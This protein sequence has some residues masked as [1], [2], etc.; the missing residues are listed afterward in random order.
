M[1]RIY[2]SLIQGDFRG[3]HKNFEAVVLEGDTVWHWWRDNSVSNQPWKRSHFITRG[4]AFPAS[5]IQ[6]NLR[7]ENHSN[8][9][10]VVPLFVGGNVEL[11]HFWHDNSDVNL[12]WARRQR[13]TEVGRRVIGPASLIQS[14]FG[15]PH[16]NFEVIVPVI[17]SSGQP[18]LRHY[19]H[20]N[21]DVQRPWS[22][23][24]QVN[25]PAHHVLGSGCLVQS[26]FGDGSHGNFEVV[27][28]VRMPDGRSVLQHY[29]H[30]NSDVN[31]PW[32]SGQVIW[33]NVK[34][35]GVIIQSSH[36]SPHS[37]FEVVVPIGAPDGRT[38]LQHVWH[39]N[40]DVNL[41]WSRGQIVSEIVSSG[42]N[43]C[44]MESD[45]RRQGRRN[46]ELLV[47][48]GSQSLV[49]Y[50]HPNDDINLPWIRDEHLLGEPAGHE[51]RN[52]SRVCQLT[53]EFDRAGWNGSEQPA[54][55][56]NKTESRFGIRGTDLGVSFEH[57]NRTYFLFG[58]TWRVGESADT[59][60]D[61]DAIAFCTDTSVQ[62]GLSLT[63]YKQ[64]PI[65][66]GISQGSFEVPL[67]GFSF[68][69]LMYV[70]F[71]TDHRKIGDTDLMGRSVLAV[72]ENDG[73]DFTP[74]LS[75]S[76]YKFINVSIERRQLDASSSR[77]LGWTENIE[78]LWIWGSGQYRSSP[79]YLAVA[80]INRLLQKTSS[81]G[82]RIPEL[83]EIVDEE[84]PIRF[85]AGGIEQPHWTSDESEAVPLF[86]AGDVGELSVRFHATFNS[87]FMTYNSGN[88]RGILLRHS[89][90]AWGP[91]SDS[92]VIFDPGW[93]RS[94][95][96]PV[97]AGYGNFM[98]IRWDVS[99][100]DWVQDDAFLSGRR[101]NEYGG[102]YGPYQIKRFSGGSRD[103]FD[104][105]FTMS[106]WNPYQSMLMR[107]RLTANALDSVPADALE[108]FML[109]VD[110][111][112]D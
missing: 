13:I 48:E 111:G 84:G 1:G 58:D 27:A 95:D 30:D 80:D 45:Y 25:D 57:R 70:F 52:T 3:A 110:A 104:L 102:E 55:A 100:V 47:D 69:D 31:R 6:S 43:G 90:T 17:N 85:Y 36:C 34:G 65:V 40:S 42:G 83:A 96:H 21:S 103:S 50:F 14:D 97:G 68:N 72:S 78:V 2:Q 67:D 7:G 35:P 64:P 24:Q 61:W 56:F 106:T 46:F 105:F 60:F 93:D 10:V 9:E 74:L 38:Y 23:G 18:E 26:D 41:P 4:A 99:R 82:E 76:R 8:F 94:D 5:I 22:A 29:W 19:W 62:N 86:S 112:G 87:Y 63:F 44:L 101:D 51:I 98:H 81:P 66:A 75:F 32:Q 91:W 28:W 20:D 108:I 39:D 12:P 59:H 73:Y 71:S 88:P 53:G 54:F 16:R 77:A 92:F 79:V 11:W 15:S 107:T 89:N 49:A 109:A 33:E 37:N